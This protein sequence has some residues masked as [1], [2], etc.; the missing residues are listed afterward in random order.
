[1]GVSINYKK[2]ASLFSHELQHRGPD[3]SG[4]YY[5]D[6]KCLVLGHNRL[7]IIDLSNSAVQPMVDESGRY[8]IVFNGEIYNYLDIKRQLII[9]GYTFFTNSD[10]EVLLKSYI[11]WGS[12]CVKK[13]E[14]CLLFVF[15]IRMK[16]IFFGQR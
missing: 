13:L 15:T 6:V 10:T 11:E 7:S 9:L 8:V 14:E 12:D 5:D 16:I 1:M 4:V 2:V 3:G